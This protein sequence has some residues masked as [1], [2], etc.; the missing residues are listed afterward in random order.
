MHCVQLRAAAGCR[1]A[2]EIRDDRGRLLVGRGAALS[3]ETCSRLADGG[4]DRVYVQDGVAD[5]LRPGGSLT[6]QTGT[7]VRRAATLAA[8]WAAG[9][10]PLPLAPVQAA[11]DGVLSDLVEARDDLVELDALRS[12]AEYHC[13]HSIAVCVYSMALGLAARLPSEHLRALG[14]GALLHDVG[15]ARHRSVWARPGPLTAE[16][17]EVVRRHPADGFDMLRRHS[18]LHLYAAHIALQ[19]HERMDGSGYPRG[20]VGEQILPLAR[21]VA[22]A[23]SYDAMT[24]DRPHAAARPP[25]QALAELRAGAG[26]LYEPSA[27]RALVGRVALYPWGTPVVLRDETVAVV[28]EQGGDPAAPIVRLLGRD[29]RRLASPA[30]VPAVAD[31]AI[32]ATLPGWPEW[33]HPPASA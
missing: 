29:H 14:A 26:R 2:C 6:A 21:L 30:E 22:V 4:L 15:N 33:L 17:W 1:L 3:A 20:L 16:Q 13:T 19:H 10:G 18:G 31:R 8:A 28:V 23:D 5:D 12:T 25:E 27:V 7:M 32:A 24:A 11:V 9:D